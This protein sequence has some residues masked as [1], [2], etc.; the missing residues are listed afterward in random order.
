MK[1]N[2]GNINDGSSSDGVVITFLS[3]RQATPEATDQSLMF[4]PSADPAP[5]LPRRWR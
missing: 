3:V 2:I 1:K 4:A 5:S